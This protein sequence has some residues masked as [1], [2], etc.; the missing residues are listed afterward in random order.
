MV[1]SCDAEIVLYGRA[2]CRGSIHMKLI[3]SASSTSW[4]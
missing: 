1:D 2:F 4:R 3:T